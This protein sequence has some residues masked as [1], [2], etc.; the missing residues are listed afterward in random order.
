MGP[1]APR[2]H[3][4]VSP[5]V[6]S[7]GTTHPWN[8]AGIGRDLVVGCDLGARVFTTVV[9]VSAQ[10]GRGVRALHPVPA[11]AI[12]AQLAAMPWDAAGAVRVGA[13]PTLA[14]VRAVSEPLRLRPWLPAVVDPVFAASGGGE[15][16]DAA[17]RYAV[18]DEL[19]SLASVVLTP[20]LEEAAFLLGISVI[21]RDT[22]S[23]SATALQ[24]RGAAA[25]LLKGGH[26][27]GDPADALATAGGVE[28]FRE[29]RIGG[30]MHGTGCTLAMALACELAGGTPIAHAVR[31]ARAYVRA[32]LARH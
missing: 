7:I 10:D 5:I 26:L 17:A 27:D 4:P 9:A 29:P 23:E 1:L 25:V 8:I 20:N 19:V 16:T 3:N 22:L 6:L 31:A 21:T 2:R 13:L 14:A 24:A 32:Q 30:S 28:I 18:R 11:D 12:A 15:L